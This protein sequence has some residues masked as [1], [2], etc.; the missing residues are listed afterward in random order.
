[1][2][3]LQREQHQEARVFGRARAAA[4][5]AVLAAVIRDAPP[6]D[7]PDIEPADTFE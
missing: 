5:V 6:V 4:V 7:A 1:M 3:V 2:H